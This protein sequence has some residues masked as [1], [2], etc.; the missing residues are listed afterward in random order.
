MKI[1]LM[2]AALSLAAVG[3]AQNSPVSTNDPIVTVVA[4]GA[5]VSEAGTAS[6]AFTIRRTGNPNNSLAVFFAL[7]GTA[8][9]GVDYQTISNNNVIIAAGAST[10]S[11]VITPIDDSLV[12]GT[13]SVILHLQPSPLLSPLV[14]YLIGTPSEAFITILDNDFPKETNHPPSVALV[15]PANNAQ[16]T[17]PASITLFANPVDSD[18]FIAQVEFFSGTNSLGVVTNNPWAGSPVNPW[19]LIWSNVPAGNY[20]LRAK[21]TDNLG[22]SAWSSYVYISVRAPDTQPTVN[23]SASDS[24]AA[25]PNNPGAFR[26]TR[27]GNTNAALT[28][29]YTVSGTALSGL[30]YAPLSG[31]VAV[32]AGVAAVEVPVTPIDD[33]LVENTEYVTVTIQPPVC[34]AIYPPPPECYRVGQSNRATVYLRDNEVAVSNARPSVVITAPANNASFTAPANIAISATASDSDGS[35]TNLEFF[36]GSSKLGH[37]IVSSLPGQPVSATLVWS[38]VGAGHYTLTAKATDNLGASTV[39][40]SVAIVVNATNEPPHTNPSVVTIVAVD[41]FAVEGPFTN[42][43]RLPPTVSPSNYPGGVITNVWPTNI[44]ET[45]TALFRVQRNGTNGALTVNYS[46]GGTASNG[47][48]YARLSGVVTIP[49]GA[50]SAE[51]KIVPIEDALVEGI[52]SVVLVLQPSPLANAVTDYVVGWPNRAGAIIVDND[53]PRPNTRQLHDALFHLCVP[54]TNGFIYRLEFSTNLVNWTPIYTNT[55]V[56]NAV[57]FVDPESPDSPHRFYRWVQETN[58]PAQ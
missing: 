41:A 51:I 11:V 55:V 6:A 22:A 39:S 7:S 45:N 49:S 46:A 9:N 52:E 34:A 44:V 23:V 37:S 12:E 1:M 19:R 47:L 43:Y 24:D 36:A 4:S 18:G 20:S 14:Q 40:P 21:A 31:T 3:L 32:P 16:F 28:V 35:V 30:D 57:Q 53:V 5:S 13:E 25:E 15:S 29:L 26:F 33:N 10:A 56:D 42:H 58:A 8:S 27:S 2:L 17:A 38:N 54:A 48:D 50:R